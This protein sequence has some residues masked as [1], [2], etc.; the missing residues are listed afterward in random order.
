MP[1]PRP[2]KPA[3]H[4]FESW[5]REKA[6]AGLTGQCA[7]CACPEAAEAVNA[8][9]E[10]R[11]R[12]EATP[13]ICAVARKL[14]EAFAPRKFSRDGLRRHVDGHTKGWNPT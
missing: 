1:K 5:A 11:H 7:I 13:G 10:M 3:A 9:I 12:G 4:P 14:N 2:K 6:T 8:L